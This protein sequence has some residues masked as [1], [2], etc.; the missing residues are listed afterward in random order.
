[1]LAVAQGITV[2]AQRESHLRAMPHRRK[3]E[4]AW[5]AMHAG[6]R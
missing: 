4:A 6:A 3:I 2:P 5:R 1:M